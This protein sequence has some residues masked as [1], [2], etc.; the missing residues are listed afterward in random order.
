MPQPLSRFRMLWMGLAAAVFAEA[1]LWAALEIYGTAGGTLR[2]VLQIITGTVFFIAGSSVEYRAHQNAVN[3]FTG[4][5]RKSGFE[6]YLEDLE[7][8]SQDDPENG[9]SGRK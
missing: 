3:S 9:K 8:G 2:T 1:L 7:E 4:S 6:H 5:N